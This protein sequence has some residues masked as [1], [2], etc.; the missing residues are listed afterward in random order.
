MSP[1]YYYNDNCIAVEV[2]Y[3]LNESK[4]MTQH[5]T[6]PDSYKVDWHET[7]YGKNLS[8]LLENPKK[9]VI[10]PGNS[11]QEIYLGSRL[12]NPLFLT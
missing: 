5:F 12:V 10:H 6:K 2:S 1:E 8:D 3:L 4:L 11:S 9:Y 7:K